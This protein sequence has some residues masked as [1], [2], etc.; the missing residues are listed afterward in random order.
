MNTKSSLIPVLAMLLG[1]GCATTPALPV[2]AAKLSKVDAEKIAIT[3]A[4]GGTVK[5]SELETEHGV[6]VWSFDI[7]TPGTA[8]ITEVQVD[9]QTG[10][11]VS[12]ENE[13]PAAQAKEKQ[14]DA[15]AKK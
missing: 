3:R 14:E 4:P 13:T 2:T 5:E 9:A 8:D 11:V 1:L 6:L 10:D 7:A 15:A 12:V